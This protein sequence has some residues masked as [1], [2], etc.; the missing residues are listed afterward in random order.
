MLS[1]KQIEDAAI[2]AHAFSSAT[3]I[4]ICLE[5]LQG[6]K[7]VEELAHSTEFTAPNC[8]QHLQVL[9]R[10]KLVRASRRGHSNFYNLENAAHIRSVLC[11]LSQQSELSLSDN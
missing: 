8:S 1:H 9:K 2:L 5:L 3:R 7:C 6:E 10:L 11:A 4:Q